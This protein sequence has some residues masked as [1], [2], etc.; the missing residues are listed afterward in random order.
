MFW[1]VS[2]KDSNRAR[3]LALHPLAD[4][5]YL[6][7]LQRYIDNLIICFAVAVLNVVIRLGSRI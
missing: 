2:P 1:A 5:H 4:A 6:Y 3:A 7:P